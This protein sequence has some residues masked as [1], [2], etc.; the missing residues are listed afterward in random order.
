LSR[1]ISPGS[2]VGGAATGAGAGAGVCVRVCRVAGAGVERA[3]RRGDAGTGVGA[4]T[5]ISG[6]VVSSW[7]STAL[8]AV[9]ATR[10]TDP[11]SPTRSLRPET[12]S[13]R[14]APDILLAPHPQPLLGF[15]IRHSRR[16]VADRHGLIVQ[17]QPGS[18]G[19]GHD[20]RGQRPQAGVVDSNCTASRIRSG[21]LRASSFCLSCDDMLTTVL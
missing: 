6:S 14:C 13:L 9:S 3:G 20:E 8:D 5:R 21:R 7:A 2:G 19:N 11:V 15:P 17:S 4:M 18:F 1:S 10:L 12:P 16:F